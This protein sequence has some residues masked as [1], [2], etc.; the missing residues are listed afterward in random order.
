M[1][2]YAGTQLSCPDTLSL[3]ALFALCARV[4][5]APC[6]CVLYVCLS[7]RAGAEEVLRGGGKRKHI[8]RALRLNGSPRR[9]EGILVLQPAVLKARRRYSFVNKGY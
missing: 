7:V 8:P 9:R 4:N 6:A 1:A 2:F 5:V 3:V